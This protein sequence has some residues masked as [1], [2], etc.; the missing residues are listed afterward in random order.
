MIVLCRNQNLQIVYRKLEDVVCGQH[1][2]GSTAICRGLMTRHF[3]E[4]TEV[5]L[6]N[7]CNQCNHKLAIVC[8]LNE[9]GTECLPYVSDLVAS[10]PD[11]KPKPPPCTSLLGTSLT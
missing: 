3:L 9:D 10:E 4:G 5:H 2:I 6:C 7:Q 1:L 8:S 11:L